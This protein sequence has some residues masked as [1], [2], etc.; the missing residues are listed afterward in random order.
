[1]VAASSTKATAAYEIS[2]LQIADDQREVATKV[3]GERLDH[4]ATVAEV[5]RRR[6][7]RSGK[8]KSKCRLPTEQKYRGSRGVKVVIHTTTRHTLEDVLADLREVISRL[9][10]TTRTEA[11]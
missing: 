3:L 10:E 8:G 7:S 6:S 4:Q 2:K 1:M 11:A 5:R 9:E